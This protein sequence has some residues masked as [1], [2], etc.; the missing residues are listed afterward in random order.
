MY[1]LECSDNMMKLLLAYD[2]IMNDALAGL[3]DVDWETALKR[4][5]QRSG[6]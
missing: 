5:V 4:D 3:C 2:I 1:V 6:G